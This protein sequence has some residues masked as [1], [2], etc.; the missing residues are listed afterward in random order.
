MTYEV[1][2]LEPLEA[3]LARQAP[4]SLLKGPQSLSGRQNLHALS[5]RGKSLRGHA[6]T[7]NEDRHLAH[8]AHQHFALFDGLGG[9]VNSARTAAQGAYFLSRLN[10]INRESRVLSAQMHTALSQ[11]NTHIYKQSVRTGLPTGCTFAGLV[12]A[13]KGAIVYSAGDTRA[14]RYRAG[15]LTQLTV[16]HRAYDPVTKRSGVARALGAAP[17]L[18]L[19]MCAIDVRADDFYLLCTDGVHD[20]LN[21]SQLTRIFTVGYDVGKQCTLLTE[22]LIR[23]KPQD[24]ASFL[25]LPGSALMKNFRGSHE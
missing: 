17:V 3:L 15:L 2:I 1:E 4:V 7:Q 12:R 9:A 6:K 25:L 11:I 5:H 16:D 21:H 8:T 20:T 24:D 13:D 10:L 19:D 22:Q 14:Y 23:A 18:P